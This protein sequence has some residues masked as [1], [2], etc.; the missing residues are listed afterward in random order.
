MKTLLKPSIL[1]I[2]GLLICLSLVACG[3]GKSSATPTLSM[4]SIQTI[5]VMDYLL[6]LTQTAIYLPTETP[7]LT[8]TITLT[9][10]TTSG[11]QLAPGGGVIPTASCYG[12]VG[13]GDVT[14]PDYTPMIPGQTFIKTWAVRN[15]GSCKWEVGFKFAFTSGDPMGGVTLVL[16]KA[17]LP[18]EE[19][20]LSVAMVAPIN[21]T[22]AVRSNWRMSTVSGVFFGE[23]QFV[24]IVLGSA[25]GTAIPTESPT[26]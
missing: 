7:T 5:A 12:L 1:A 22:G 20:E 21:K 13:L 14:I 3:A 2:P 15:S 17:V 9:P 6:G 4:Q 18:G 8:P 10:T 26:P 16:D 19:I 23:E 11:T 24:I 25:T